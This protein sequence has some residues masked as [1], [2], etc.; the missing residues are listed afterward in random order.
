M[1]TPSGISAQWGFVTESAYGTPVTVTRFLPIR[2]ESI[3]D[4]YERIEGDDIIANAETMRQAQVAAGNVAF[5]GGIETF[6]F[7]RNIGLFFLQTLGGN[8]TTGSGPTYTHVATPA[9]LTGRSMT[10]QFGRT[11]LGGTVRPWTYE[12]V[13]VRQ[14]T[15]GASP[16]EYATVS[17]D[18]VAEDVKTGTA[19]ASASYPTGLSRFRGEDL[20]VTIGGSPVVVRSFEITF[21][22]SLDDNRRAV[23]SNLIREPLRN[24][25]LS[26]TGSLEI[27]WTDLTH[28][29]R[30]AGL[31]YAALS[32]AFTSAPD[33]VTIACNA[34]F[35]QADEPIAG[36]GVIYQTLSFTAVGT[37]DSNTVTVTTINADATA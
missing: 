14:M 25:L 22:N 24:D 23:G 18:V 28:Y 20:A 21:A 1:P 4:S 13:K 36:R 33:S 3:T 15:I 8:A 7:N 32:A 19:L 10:M 31:T 11:D 30:V 37:S 12:G 29:N 9:D 6:L 27:E 35:D 2:S 34:R 5:S 17:M 26:I 16:G